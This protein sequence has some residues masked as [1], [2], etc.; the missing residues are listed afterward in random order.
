MIYNR[1]KKRGLHLTRSPATPGQI[2]AIIISTLILCLVNT[3]ILSEYG[4][5]S[6][7]DRVCRSR[8]CRSRL[9]NSCGNHTASCRWPSRTRAL[10]D[11]TIVGRTR[12]RPSID[13][14]TRNIVH[15][16]VTNRSLS[17]VWLRRRPS[18]ETN[19]WS[20]T[21]AVE[22]GPALQAPSETHPLFGLPGAEPASTYQALA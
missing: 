16:V 21:V 8:H 22:V 9:C 2:L 14:P 1:H 19:R 17:I 13:I 12:S 4:T 7:N 3:L 18:R 11:P 10:S 20:C 5:R 6:S 15:A